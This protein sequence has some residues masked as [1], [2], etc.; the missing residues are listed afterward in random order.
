MKI[1]ER[2]I[3][4]MMREGPF[5]PID[6]LSKKSDG[7]TPEQ[8][9]CYCSTLITQMDQTIEEY[10]LYN[11]LCMAVYGSVSMLSDVMHETPREKF[12]ASLVRPYVRC[13]YDA[14]DFCEKVTRL[15][16]IEEGYDLAGK[17]RQS[18]REK[19]DNRQ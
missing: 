12:T 7:A 18:R 8:V 2:V 5:H 6:L 11:D 3:F 15:R 10:C 13:V 17:T 1:N 14:M 9:Y 4:T 19:Y 16:M